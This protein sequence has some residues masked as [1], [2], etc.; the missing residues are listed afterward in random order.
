M[1]KDLTIINTLQSYTSTNMG[2]KFCDFV[3]VHTPR[4]THDFR[5]ILLTIPMISGSYYSQY[6]WFQVHTPRHTHDFRFILLTIP[7]ISG[8]YSSPYPWFQV[9]T[10]HNTHDFRFIL[11]TIPMI[12]TVDILGHNC[13][14]HQIKLWALVMLQMSFDVDVAGFGKFDTYFSAI[15]AKD[16]RFFCCGYIKIPYI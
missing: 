12:C 14:A 2:V 7:M 3:Q 10:T 1:H 11:L 6:P 15:S 16:A 9:H 4:H 13:G 8:S 5:F